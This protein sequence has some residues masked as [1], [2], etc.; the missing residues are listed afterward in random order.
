MM[1]SSQ[2]DRSIGLN[3]NTFFL[4]V[5]PILQQDVRWGVL[6]GVVESL[7][8]ERRD[9]TT[10]FPHLPKYAEYKADLLSFLQKG[11]C[12]PKVLKLLMRSDAAIVHVAWHGESLD[13]DDKDIS[14]CKETVLG[15]KPRF[16]YPMRVQCFNI[17]VL[18]D[19]TKTGS[20]EVLSALRKIYNHYYDSKVAFD[21]SHADKGE[22]I[23]IV[24]PSLYGIGVNLNA[25]MRRIFQPE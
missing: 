9:V 12:E 5:E 7:S 23:I 19:Q 14:D 24:K 25:L 8:Y 10:V 17:E 6:R 16:D 15:L 11:T 18:L 21:L 3:T 1:G 2:F 22:D 20:L 13:E 4:L